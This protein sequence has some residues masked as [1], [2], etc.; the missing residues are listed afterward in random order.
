VVSIAKVLPASDVIEASRDA[1]TWT[2]WFLLAARN[3]YGLHSHF[4]KAAVYLWTHHH[5]RVYIRD[6]Y[7]T[8]EVSTICDS[9]LH[10]SSLSLGILHQKGTQESWNWDSFSTWKDLAASSPGVRCEAESWMF[11]HGIYPSWDKASTV[12]Y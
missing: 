7:K 12:W 9:A 5:D 6:C 10:S 11:P 3:T 8:Y 4:D 1:F 2:S